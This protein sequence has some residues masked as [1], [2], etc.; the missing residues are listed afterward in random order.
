MCIFIPL[1]FFKIVACNRRKHKSVDD[2]YSRQAWISFDSQC[3]NVDSTPHGFFVLQRDT[4]SIVYIQRPILTS[5]F[6]L[7]IVHERHERVINVCRGV[8][9]N[10]ISGNESL[11]IRINPACQLNRTGRALSGTWKIYLNP[12][13]TDLEITDCSVEGHQSSNTEHSSFFCCWLLKTVSIRCCRHN[14]S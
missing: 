11:W 7:Y 4:C 14:C 8:G 3:V 1:A 5:Q 2:V 9:W 6:V 12:C 10:I 13:D